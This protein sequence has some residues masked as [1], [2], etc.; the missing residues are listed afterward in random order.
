M[1]DTQKSGNVNVNLTLNFMLCLPTCGL[2][3]PLSISQTQ[4][5]FGCNLWNLCVTLKMKKGQ[6]TLST[7]EYTKLMAKINFLDPL[8]EW[9]NGH[10]GCV[11]LIEY[12]PFDFL[13]VTFGVWIKK[14]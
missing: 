10:C 9:K 12:I 8:L 3:S 4:L 2:S 6:N 13:Y 5:P 1:V 11:D 7:W 14:L